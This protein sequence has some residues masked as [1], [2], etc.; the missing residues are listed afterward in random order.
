[1]KKIS[2]RFLFVILF[3]ALGLPPTA[4]AMLPMMLL[5]M[6]GGVM[7]GG[8]AHGAGWLGGQR[9]SSSKAGQAADT[10][11]HGTAS[12]PQQIEERAGDGSHDHDQQTADP[13]PDRDPTTT[14]GSPNRS[15]E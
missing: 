6:G 10:H 3:G 14:L 9:G 5:A 4:H 11:D 1:M 15:G 12:K 2:G 13:L 7:G 8:M